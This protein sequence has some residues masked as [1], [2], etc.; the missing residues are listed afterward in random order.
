LAF[1]TKQFEINKPLDRLPTAPYQ[2]KAKK[3]SGLT[4]LI[5]E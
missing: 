4:A 3:R 5:I 2:A 1:P